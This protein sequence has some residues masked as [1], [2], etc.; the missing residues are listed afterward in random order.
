MKLPALTVGV[1]GC[2]LPL[3]WR[4]RAELRVMA[5][6]GVHAIFADGEDLIASRY[7]IA[8]DGAIVG[9]VLTLPFGGQDSLVG[10]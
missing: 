9:H 8:A 1:V 2:T 5:V 6:G 4:R 10:D 7:G 3:I